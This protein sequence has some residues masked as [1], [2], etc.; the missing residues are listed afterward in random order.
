MADLNNPAIENYLFVS[1]RC[2]NNTVVHDSNILVEKGANKAKLT[3]VV[4][5]NTTAMTPIITKTHLND[6]YAVFGNYDGIPVISPLSKSPD[7]SPLDSGLFG[8]VD[9]SNQSIL[10]ADYSRYLEMIVLGGANFLKV[11]HKKC[12]YEIDLSKV[13]KAVGIRSK[14]DDENTTASHS[15]NFRIFSAC[16]LGFINQLGELVVLNLRQFLNRNS[17]PLQPT[18]VEVSSTNNMHLT[19]FDF[20]GRNIFGLNESGVVYKVRYQKYSSNSLRRIKKKT[21]QE[22][23][24]SECFTSLLSI[25]ET[26][27]LLV[28]SL[29]G[30]KTISLRLLDSIQL[31]QKHQASIESLEGNR[32]F[33]FVHQM[34]LIKKDKLNFAVL[35]L[36]YKNLHLVA[37]SHNQIFL[38]S[39]IESFHRHYFSSMELIGRVLVCAGM[40][41]VK[42]YEINMA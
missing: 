2:R 14:Y 7:A 41:L 28:A 32:R 12:K 31:H 10:W 33:N 27:S 38:C 3:Q 11:L 18:D 30:E 40:N 16:L 34:T 23:Q 42:H 20:G 22:I 39:T 37:I 17:E 4:S 36:A 8:S 9:S 24:P 26:E 21:M 1:Y 6:A 5:E 25:P 19:E 35:A 15:R 29:V 13:P